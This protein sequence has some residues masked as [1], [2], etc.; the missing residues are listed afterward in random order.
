LIVIRVKLP[1]RK[2]IIIATPLLALVTLVGIDDLLGMTLYRTGTEASVE[3]IPPR[4]EP[5]ER[6][7]VILPG[8][9]MSGE[10]TARAFAPFVLKHDALVGVDYADHGVNPY[11]IYQEILEALYS[12]KPAH[13][14]FYA[15]SMGGLVASYVL[16]KYQ[17]G[18]APFGKVSLVLDTVPGG[19]ADIK[20]P[21][22]LLDLSCWYR[23]GP[24]SSAI[25]AMIANL[26]EQPTL[27][28]GANLALAEEARH[29][30]EWVGM[31]ALTTQACF[32]R[33]FVPPA[34]VYELKVLMQSVVYLQG[35]HSE[36][37][38]LVKTAKSINY[39]RAIF[40]ALQVVTIAGRNG[41]WH[42]PL[43]ERP[44]ET[45][46]AFIGIH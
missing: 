15:A 3:V 2:L 28:K 25:W 18:G 41:R 35:V 29:S 36:N 34:G 11:N 45:V 44:E 22:W 4:A 17:E 16:A 33:R 21:G 19:S 42:V 9:A 31:P 30:G 23:G 40:P 39:W 1:R 46:D 37:D 27:E 8:Y 7:I 26:S 38:P 13:V 5:A 14:I 12:I 32:I 43:V 24:V 10:I 6:A 20:R